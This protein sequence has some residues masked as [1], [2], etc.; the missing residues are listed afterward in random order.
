[1]YLEET[2]LQYAAEIDPDEFARWV[3][4]KLFHS[5]IPRYDEIVN[6]H[7]YT[8]SSDE[9]GQVNDEKDFLEL[10]EQAID[11]QSHASKP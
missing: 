1:M 10:L 6:P 3:F 4:P 11:S 9:V 7:G 8:V 5:R 2:A